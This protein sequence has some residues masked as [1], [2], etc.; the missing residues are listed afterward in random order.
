MKHRHLNLLNQIYVPKGLDS[1][2]PLPMCPREEIACPYKLLACTLENIS[3][4]PIELH[5]IPMQR[6]WITWRKSFYEGQVTTL[7]FYVCVEDPAMFQTIPIHG[8]SAEMHAWLTRWRKQYFIITCPVFMDHHQHG[9]EMFGV[10]NTYGAFNAP[11][12]PLVD[13]CHQ[14]ITIHSYTIGNALTLALAL[15]RTGYWSHH[16]LYD[17]LERAFLCEYMPYIQPVPI[18]YIPFF[19]DHVVPHI[20]DHA[21]YYAVMGKDP[22]HSSIYHLLSTVDEP[23][24]EPPYIEQVHIMAQETSLIT[25]PVVAS[26]PFHKPGPN[27]IR[28]MFYTPSMD[29]DDVACY[30]LVGFFQSMVRNKR[31]WKWWIAHR[32]A[33]WNLIFERQE[34]TMNEK[35]QYILQALF[36]IYDTGSKKTL[37]YSRVRAL[38]KD[39]CMQIHTEDIQKW[40]HRHVQICWLVHHL[41]QRDVEVR[42]QV[43]HCPV[44]FLK[45]LETFHQIDICSICGSNILTSYG[46]IVSMILQEHGISFHE[47]T[48]NVYRVQISLSTLMNTFGDTSYNIWKKQLDKRAAWRLHVLKQAFMVPTIPRLDE[49]HGATIHLIMDDFYRNHPQQLYVL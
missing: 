19:V 16:D 17:A 39:L 44:A 21:K 18:P 35:I 49:N 11:F 29:D 47:H 46:P 36:H 24:A 42:M 2:V 32:R 14:L 41:Q 1:H 7:G 4:D 40:F 10:G 3:W 15:H 26:F 43:F 31:A 48:Q 30:D 20:C 28:T 33:I 22:A 37:A 12:F 13:L 34:G 25:N 38:W 9:H 6:T 5:D 8:T 23:D 27:T 45:D